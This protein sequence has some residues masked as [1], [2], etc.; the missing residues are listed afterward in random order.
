MGSRKATLKKGCV[1]CLAPVSSGS[2]LDCSN[3]SA[4]VQEL[5]ELIA[6]YQ[7]L[8]EGGRGPAIA[9]TII[10]TA[11]QCNM[12]K[13]CNLPPDE[14]DTKEM[15]MEDRDLIVGNVYRKCV[16]TSVSMQFLFVL[17]TTACT[18]HGPLC[19]CVNVC[20]HSLLGNC[21]CRITVSLFSAV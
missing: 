20:A 2:A 6:S 19:V 16:A 5:K 8:R 14:V 17:V 15:P 7:T 11:R 13:D 9:S 3:S 10:S 21:A 12:D 18:A 4:P 1:H